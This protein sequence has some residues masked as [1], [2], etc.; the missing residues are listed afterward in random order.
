MK[1]ASRLGDRRIER[2]AGLDEGFE[3]VGVEHLG[4][5][6]DVVAG[7][8]A[9]AREQ[10]LE[11]RQAVVDADAGRH[12]E[13]R[14]LGALEGDDVDRPSLSVRACAAMSTSAEAA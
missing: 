9:R 5:Q 7:G 11:V 1:R 12:A 13:P 8:I 6:V 3:A 10:V 2:I 4:P 14:E